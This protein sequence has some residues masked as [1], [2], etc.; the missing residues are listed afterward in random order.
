MQSQSEK[1][2][3]IDHILSL[4]RLDKLC[5]KCGG[6]LEIEHKSVCKKCD[7][8]L[9][10]KINLDMI[11]TCCMTIRYESGLGKGVLPH[12]FKPTISH[13]QKGKGNARKKKA[14]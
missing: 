7:L 9:N 4:Y 11:D 2:E 10:L 12:G 5:S 3:I 6:P 8:L 1:Q 14:K 13:P